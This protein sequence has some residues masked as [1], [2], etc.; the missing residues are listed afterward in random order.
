MSSLNRKGE[1]V[2]A[3]NEL[4]GCVDSKD[5]I[6]ELFLVRKLVTSKQTLCV[7]RKKRK[8]KKHLPA[9]LR[10]DLVKIKPM[11]SEAVN[12][13]SAYDPVAYCLVKFRLLE[14]EAEVENQPITMFVSGPCDWL[15]LQL[16][17]PTPTIYF[18]L[19]HKQRIHKQNQ[20]KWKQSAILPSLI[21]LSL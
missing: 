17:L 11:E 1:G 14:P 19:D 13:A 10:Y 7:A 15:V 21:L 12:T 8:G 16:L 2:T 18:S 6:F 4:Y 5:L 9:L 20:K 3:R